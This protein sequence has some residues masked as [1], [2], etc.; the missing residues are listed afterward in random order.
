VTVALS[1]PVASDAEARLQELQNVC[2]VLW[3]DRAAPLVRA[4]LVAML[5]QIRVAER[6]VREAER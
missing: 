5:D 6:T 2:R 3:P 4:E 1:S